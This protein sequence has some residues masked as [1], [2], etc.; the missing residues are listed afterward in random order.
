M[1]FRFLMVCIGLSIIN[2]VKGQTC[3]SGGIP[4]SNNIGL[5]FTED[6]SLLFGLNYDFNNLNTLKNETE[7]LG[8]NSRLRTTHSVLINVGY[9]FL[10]RWSIEGLFTWVNQ[11]RIISEFGSEN[12]DE[13]YGIG[14][15]IVLLRYSI[16][17]NTAKNWNFDV[18]FG[19]KIPFGSTTKTNDQGIVLNA[20]L[21]PGSNAWDLVYLLGAS[22]TFAFRP[23]MTFSTRIVYR[24]TGENDSYFETS[25]YE[26]G[27]E[28]QA[29][30]TITDQ[31]LI[32]KTL[33]N[34]GLS[35]KY[36]TAEKDQ[37]LGFDIPNTGG[38]WLFVIPNFSVALFQNA[39]FNLAA[40]LPL[41][42]KP[43]G[44][45]LTPTYRL[46]TGFLFSLFKKPQAVKIN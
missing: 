24:Q 10:K 45:Q 22:K 19:A 46:T 4:L 1:V 5:T 29:F 16:L 18:G 8:D 30:L 37:T 11:R 26:F 17:K 28:L 23:T 41:Y 9:S 3:C 38:D 2:T 12:L 44:I 13:S 25:T 42:S 34:P 33:I 15:A 40:E 6:N 43:D 31:F 20:D 39:S 14:D 32:K 35:F 21:Q 27:N 36:R 7:T